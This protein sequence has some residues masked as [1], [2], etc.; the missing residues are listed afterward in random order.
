MEVPDEQLPSQVQD[1]ISKFKRIAEVDPT[2]GN[3]ILLGQ[4]GYI[5]KHED[6]FQDSLIGSGLV[7]AKKVFSILKSIDYPGNIFH[8]LGHPAHWTAHSGKLGSGYKVED[9]YRTPVGKIEAFVIERDNP[10]G[11]TEFLARQDFVIFYYLFD[12]TDGPNR[13][14]NDTMRGV[15]EVIK[16]ERKDELSRIKVKKNYVLDYLFV[17]KKALVIGYYFGIMVPA[18]DDIPDNFRKEMVIEIPNGKAKIIAVRNNISRDKLFG[19]LDMFKLILPPKQE[20]LGDFGIEAKAPPLLFKTSNGLLE[21]NKTSHGFGTFMAVACFNSAVLKRYEDDKRYRIDDD[22]GVHYADVWG[23]YRGIWRL[24]DELI[25]VHLG[26]LAEGLP[27]D[28]WSHWLQYNVEPVSEDEL[29][30]LQKIQSIQKLLNSLVLEIGAFE[31]RQ[32]FYMTKR[33]VRTSEPLFRFENKELTQEIIKELKKTFTR[34]TT[35]AE[36]L[37]RMVWLYKLIIDS[38]SNKTLSSFV[39]SYDPAAK[40]DGQGKFKKSSTLL[41]TLL[42]FQVI[43]KTCQSFGLTKEETK[44]K[45]KEYHSLIN[46]KTNQSDDFLMKEIAQKIRHLREDFEIIS[47]IGKLRSGAGG[48]HV[49]STKEFEQAMAKLGFPAEPHNFLQVYRTVINRLIAFFSA[50]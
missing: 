14:F 28:E 46:R 38:L 21:I 48:A 33:N 6:S 3:Y 1:I 44:A 47:V 19:R 16:F 8:N 11:F 20:M 25:A 15:A 13:L 40:F 39:D 9:Y 27:Y 35:K 34:E 24:G 7:D 50:T 32:L 45:T 10:V 41:L 30:E 2:D 4:N 12:K 23:I 5:E 17:R 36:F 42:E 26:D 29:R 18:A 31:E 49:G 43:E 37:N 22:G